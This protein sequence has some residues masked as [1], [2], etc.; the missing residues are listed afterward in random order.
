MAEAA[1][2]R[3]PES[4]RRLQHHSV[5]LD[6]LRRSHQCRIQDRSSSSQY[7]DPNAETA[8]CIGN[9]RLGTSQIEG[10]DVSNLVHVE[11]QEVRV[12]TLRR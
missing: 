4:N 11:C 9:R 7:A 2:K 10:R 8:I 1:G 12:S 3:R 6:R 5:P